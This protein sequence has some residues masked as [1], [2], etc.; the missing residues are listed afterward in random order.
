VSITKK[1]LLGFIILTLAAG[2]TFL[3]AD[4][5]DDPPGI[6]DSGNGGNGENGQDEEKD[7]TPP[8]AFRVLSL[9]LSPNGEWLA[10][11]K[12]YANRLETVVK[13]VDS[14]EEVII[15]E[16]TS[17]STLYWSPNGQQLL[18]QKST[19]DVIVFMVDTQSTPQ[20]Q[21]IIVTPIPLEMDK[22]FWSVWG[23]ESDD[24]FVLVYR[25][26]HEE[27]YVEVINLQGELSY[28]SGSF[29]RYPIAQANSKYLS[30]GM[31]SVYYREGTFVENFGGYDHIYDA[32]G[33]AVF[34]AFSEG[35]RI[36]QGGED[37]LYYIDINRSTY[38]IIQLDWP[39]QIL[40]GEWRSD[41]E[42]YLL[43]EEGNRIQIGILDVN[44]RTVARTD[45]DVPSYDAPFSSAGA[46]IVTTNKDMN[47]I[48]FHKAN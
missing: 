44:T 25:N 33:E 3:E 15:E 5:P 11:Q 38:E 21:D 34:V 1:I 10:L 36:V 2:C 4:P 41:T 12:Q 28:T 26:E 6:V 35:G 42:L 43:F 40:Y 48:F 39:V 20:G 37:N 14:Q 16:I 24:N 32:G 18:Y 9:Y 23:W 17:D 7:K 22:V 45:L 29:A 46:L 8:E 19:D 13:N 30:A 31:A 47:E 27:Y